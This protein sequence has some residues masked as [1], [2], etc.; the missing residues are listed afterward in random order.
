MKVPYLEGQYTG[1][2]H[3]ALHP[4]ATALVALLGSHLGNDARLTG[5][6]TKS[7]VCGRVQCV[8][9][10][11]YHH[12]CYKWLQLLLQLT[13]TTNPKDEDKKVGEKKKLWKGKAEFLPHATAG[14]N[15]TWSPNVKLTQGLQDIMCW[16][17]KQR[18]HNLNSQ[19][20]KTSLSN[21]VPSKG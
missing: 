1:S 20:D 7:T 5:E 18:R 9:A 4:Y 15:K 14:A 3:H 21:L 19:D 17:V 11:R 2:T 12:Y 16:N 10:A 13:Q 8:K 6:T